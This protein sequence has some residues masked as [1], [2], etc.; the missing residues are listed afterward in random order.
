MKA[1]TLDLELQTFQKMTP[2]EKLVWLTD[3]LCKISMYGRGTYE[4][5]TD[6]VT[7][8]PDLRLFNELMHR[9]AVFTKSVAKNN[10]NRIADADLFALLASNFKRLN[11]PEEEI[12]AL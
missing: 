1:I 5:G 9:V 10:E 4:Y 2:S 6:Q 3:M 7:N 12:L 8:P 11:I